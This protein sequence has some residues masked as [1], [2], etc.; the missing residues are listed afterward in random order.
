MS[1]DA[2]MGRYCLT[3]FFIRARKYAWYLSGLIFFCHFSVPL[4]QAAE[5]PTSQVDA[6][7]LR[8]IPERYRDLEILAQRLKSGGANTVIARPLRKNGTI[9]T[10]ALTNLIFLSHQAGLRI[11][12]ILPTR[13]DS[14]AL[15]TH[16]D[17]EDIRYDL[18]SGTLQVTGSL[19]LANP[20]V[21]AHLVK[22]FKEVAAFSVD[23]ILFDHDFRYES[24]EG[25][26][27]SILKEYTRKYGVKFVARKAFAKVSSAITEM[28]SGTFDKSFWQWSELKRDV[29]VS[30]AQEIGKGCRAVQGAIKLGIPLHVPGGE[31]PQLALARF[32]YDMNAFRKIDVDFYWFELRSSEGED[33]G[34]RSYK[35]NF[36]HFSRLVKA[37]STMQ[38]DPAK[39]IVAIPA[40]ESGKVLP[41]FEIEDTTALAKQAGKTGLAY[42][43]EQTAVP[44]AALTK[45]LFKRE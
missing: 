3:G 19:D 44:P 20:Q 21:V 30:A 42:I 39:M 27:T 26:S 33:H 14:S 31:T 40:T 10:A 28:D 6:F 2:L 7:F 37:A 12:V 1:I 5:S 34:G 41:L 32:S 8:S 38:K 4:L 24:T 36:E 35:K 23:G 13:L 45:K 29:V 9:D 15:K 22:R 25:M 43:V 17:W 16:P 18:G 11:Y